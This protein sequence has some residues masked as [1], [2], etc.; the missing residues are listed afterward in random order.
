MRPVSLPPP[1]SALR[2]A[3]PW[4]VVALVLVVVS[5]TVLRAVGRPHRVE[6]LTAE[7]ATHIGADLTRCPSPQTIYRYGPY[8]GRAWFGKVEWFAAVRWEVDTSAA[9]AQIVNECLDL[10]PPFGEDTWRA[11]GPDAFRDGEW[12]R[13]RHFSV[14]DDAFGPPPRAGSFV[15]TS[16]PFGRFQENQRTVYVVEGPGSARI[17]HVDLYLVNVT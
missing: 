16:E 13:E 8:D 4:L 3:R 5:G 17:R 11:A 1:R 10:S 9:A 15:Q 2:R 12:T 6:T 7:L 14:A